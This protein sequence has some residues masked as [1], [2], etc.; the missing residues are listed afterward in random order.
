VQQPYKYLDLAVLQ[1]K[2]YTALL[3]SNHR[4]S[5]KSAYLNSIFLVVIFLIFT[6]KIQ[7]Y[8]CSQLDRACSRSHSKKQRRKVILRP[9]S[10]K[11]RQLHSILKELTF[12]KIY[13]N[14]KQ[15]SLNFGHLLIPNFL[16]Q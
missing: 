13:K 16:H 8:Y 6:R 14:V 10:K 3:T 15:F 4:I 2:T 7:T 12:S 9:K 1:A 11:N 5:D